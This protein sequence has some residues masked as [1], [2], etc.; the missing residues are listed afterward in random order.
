MSYEHRRELKIARALGWFSVGLGA[1]AIV[2]PRT[3]G[4]TI[5]VGGRGQRALPWIGAREIATGA[6]ILAQRKPASGVWARVG[7]DLMDLAFLAA[8]GGAK[9]AR[10]NKLI[11]TALAVLGVTALDVRSGRQLSGKE[12]VLRLRKAIL[13]NKPAEELYNYWHDFS[14]LPQFMNNLESVQVI[15]EK[16]SHW[17]ARAGGMS[18][19]WE[20]EIVEDTPNQFIA[21]RSVGEADLPNWG[22]V[23]FSPRAQGKGTEVKVELEYYT[24]GGILGSVAAK[25]LGSH[26]EQ[27]LDQALRRF[28]QLMETGEIATTRGQPAGAGRASRGGLGLSD[29]VVQGTA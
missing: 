9:D 14:R 28:Q 12:D 18:F 23:R 13:I 24:P 11:G 3:L 20:A 21:W 19:E 15:D 6:V 1:A 8:A 7:G 29:M 2:L 5:G 22:S 17:T 26:P 10:K 4:R 16:R 27:Q 25:F